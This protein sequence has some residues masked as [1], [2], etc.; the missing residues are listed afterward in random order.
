MLPFWVGHTRLDMGM[1]TA[2]DGGDGGGTCMDRGGNEEQL[3]PEWNASLA[4][5]NRTMAT[6][7]Q[8]KKGEYGSRVRFSQSAEPTKAEAYLENTKH[9]CLN[10]YWSDVWLIYHD[11][12]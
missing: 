4:E 9:R 3:V 8:R 10:G 11:L 1:D 7:Q 6:C 5:C 2:E 12:V